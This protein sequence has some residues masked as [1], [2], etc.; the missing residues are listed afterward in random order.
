MS[1][2]EI[3]PEVMTTEENRSNTGA[4][5]RDGSRQLG[6][7]Q[8]AKGNNVHCVEDWIGYGRMLR[9]VR[10]QDEQEPLFIRRNQSTEGGDFLQSVVF[11][12]ICQFE[13]SH[14]RR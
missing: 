14:Q 8:H 3:V 5:A 4:I 11:I 1:K 13:R 9:L 10:F 7:Q 2:G 12:D 6:Y